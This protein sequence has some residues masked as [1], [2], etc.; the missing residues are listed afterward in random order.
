[1]LQHKATGVDLDQTQASKRNARVIFCNLYGKGLFC[2]FYGKGWHIA[3]YKGEVL[4]LIWK[5]LYCT[6][7]GKSCYEWNLQKQQKERGQVLKRNSLIITSNE[8]WN[9]KP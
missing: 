3:L 8:F 1:M 6:L 5:R 2:L 7:G 4:Q 9:N